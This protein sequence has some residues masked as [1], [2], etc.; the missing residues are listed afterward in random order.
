MTPTDMTPT[1]QG[2]PVVLV[3]G[4][5]VSGTMWHPVMEHLRHRHPVA[6]P[7]LP[8]HGR[9]R[10][11]EFTLAGAVE[12]VAEAVDG[13]GGRAL[14]VGLSL[15]GFTAIETAR[16]HPG[17]VLGLVAVGCSAQPR[18][19]LLAA[20][21]ATAAL[22]GRYPAAADRIS[23]WAFRSAL[24]GAPGAAMVRGGLSCEVFPDVVEAVA[25]TDPRAALRS[26]PGP[27]W[28]VNGERDQFRRGER[29]FLAACRDGRLQVVPRRGHIG[30]LA[31]P[32]VLG[33]VVLDAAAAVAVRSR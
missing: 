23:R 24:P 26:Y 2:L 33:R 27:V 18:G 11:E 29:Q 15:G 19:A 13:L 8:G 20:Y 30:V 28:L 21:R 31:E 17:K 25:A 14:L 5:R 3:H 7:D 32:E 1:E 12:A 6:A 10:G 22:A 9:R 4:T 16:V